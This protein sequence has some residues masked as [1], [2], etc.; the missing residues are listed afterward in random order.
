MLYR[1][2]QTPKPRVRDRSGQQ[3]RSGSIQLC[4]QEKPRR[5]GAE[6]FNEEPGWNYFDWPPDFGAAPEFGLFSF[7]DGDDAAGLPERALPS[8]SR[9]DLAPPLQPSSDRSEYCRCSD[10]RKILS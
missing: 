1:V 9:T 6:L 10:R 7:I 5:S 4:L 2:S 3:R 8:F